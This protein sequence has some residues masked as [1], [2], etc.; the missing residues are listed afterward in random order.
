V[1]VFRHNH[2]PDYLE[3]VAATGLF[4]RA[5]KDSLRVRCV[6]Q[7]LPPV[8]SERD[9]VETVGLLKTDESPRHEEKTRALFVY[10]AV[11]VDTRVC[12]RGD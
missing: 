2:I 12:E 1:D 4:E 9:E 6:E 11:M 5:F 3:P 10:G 7:G 8:T